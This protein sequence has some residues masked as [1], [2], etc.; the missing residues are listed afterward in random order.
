MFDYFYNFIE[1]MY[2]IGKLTS[3]DMASLV[4]RKYITETE[5]QRIQ[6]AEV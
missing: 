4:E 1:M 5:S 6:N 2:K 3:E